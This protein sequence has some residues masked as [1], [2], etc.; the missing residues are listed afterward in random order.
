LAADGA[1]AE[2]RARHAAH[3]CDV[4]EAAEAGVRTA[5]EGRWARDVAADFGNLRAAHLW[6]IETAEVDLDARLLVALWNYGLQR[7]SAEYFR[8]VEEAFGRLA[9]GDHPLVPELHGIAALGAWLRGDLGKC[10]RACEAAFDAEKRLH[11][12]LSLPARMAVVLAA[13]YAP[14]A[15]EAHV[16]LSAQVPSRFLEVV[17]WTRH[18]GDPY[19]LVYS[20]INGSLGMVMAGDLG[21]AAALADRALRV[22]R[23]SGCPTSLAWALFGFATALEDAEPER[24]QELLEEGVGMARLAESRM[25]LGLSLSRLATIHRRLGRPLDAVPLLVELLDHCDRLGNRPLL[26]HTIREAVMCLGH[27]Q[28]G[29]TGVRLLAAVDRAEMVMPM[30]PPDRAQVAKLVGELREA[31]GDDAFAAATVSGASLSREEAVVL[32]ARSLASVE[33]AA[34]VATTS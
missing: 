33:S 8:W 29:D 9:F 34:S 17:T 19:W 1:T 10:M 6:A 2:L 7:L 24:A 21:G 14:S 26:W 15:D 32:T 28:P 4:A 25:V 20:M 18:L 30:L 31:V 16:A 23:G 22:A 3:Y 5:D 27:L 12:R 11:S 13:A